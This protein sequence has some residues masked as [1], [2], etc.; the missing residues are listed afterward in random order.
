MKNQNPNPGDIQQDKVS[1]SVHCHRTSLHK[2][3]GYIFQAPIAPLVYH[4]TPSLINPKVS[5]KN[6]KKRDQQGLGVSSVLQRPLC[7]PCWKLRLSATA[8]PHFFGPLRDL[9]SFP[10]GACYFSFSS[11]HAQCRWN[12][13][14]LM[15]TA[16]SSQKEEESCLLE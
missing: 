7:S 2:L 11:T 3:P 15:A 8:P 12:W 1:E 14:V 4:R 16:T 10:V 9:P 13:G 6:L 5:H